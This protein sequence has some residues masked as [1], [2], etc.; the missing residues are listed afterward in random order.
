M[1][2]T[3]RS[4]LIVPEILQEAV[5]GEF[6]G[7]TALLNSGAAA[8]S[9]TL[10]ESARG[11]DV[12]KVPYFGTIGE[13]ED[14]AEAVALTPANIVMTSETATV[15]HSGKA[16]EITQWAQIAAAYA[17]PY[18]ELARQ[19]R[20]GFERRMDRALID[21]ANTT[22]LVHDVYSATT[23]RTLNWD[24]VVDARMRFGDEQ[25]DLALLVVHSKVLGDLLKL[26]DGDGRPLL[27][28]DLQAEDRVARFA[29]VP[30]KV[31]DRLAPESTNPPKYTS[32]LIKRNALA[33]WYNG[34]PEVQADRDILRDTQVAAV[35][36]YWI[37]HRYSRAPGS[38][39]TGVVKVVHN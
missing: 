36:V 9:S 2:V 22:D 10:P 18:A 20:V 19:L 26:K 1:P 15:Q 29:G 7:V 30:V 34:S 14:V 32:L 6:V 27:V 4:N 31:S 5:R 39:R 11:G 33:L 23:P 28:N 38:T 25:E 21:A 37:A 24:V 12:L 8:V 35:H 13:Y 16:I 17:D 3:V